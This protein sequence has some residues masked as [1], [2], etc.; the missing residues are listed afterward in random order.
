MEK[1]VNVFIETL[2]SGFV[3]TLEGKKIAKTSLLQVQEM[4]VDEINRISGRIGHT[5]VNTMSIQ[6]SYTENP[7]Q[8]SKT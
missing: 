4:M 2:D 8:A 5:Q 6:I 7:P 3:V 1:Y